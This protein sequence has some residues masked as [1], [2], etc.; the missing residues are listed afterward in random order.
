MVMHLIHVDLYLESNEEVLLDCTSQVHKLRGQYINL[1]TCP[2]Y[3][4]PP[5]SAYWAINLIKIQ[6]AFDMNVDYK[7]TKLNT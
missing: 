2:R 7:N 5:G 6:K 1:L 3:G 4:C